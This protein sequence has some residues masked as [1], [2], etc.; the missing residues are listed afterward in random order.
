[1]KTADT[2]ELFINLTSSMNG[3]TVIASYICDF[4]NACFDERREYISHRDV[5][6]IT[7]LLPGVGECLEYPV[8]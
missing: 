3:D 2:D 6:L 5:A 7:L 1:M 8:D 4:V